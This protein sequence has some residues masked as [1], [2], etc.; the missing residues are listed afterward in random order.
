MDCIDLTY[1]V[2]IIEMFDGFEVVDL[3]DEIEIVI[4]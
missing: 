3:T 4:L 1:E 2:E